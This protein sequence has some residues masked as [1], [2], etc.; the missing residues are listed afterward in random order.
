MCKCRIYHALTW[1]TRPLTASMGMAKPTPLLAPDGDAIA[2]LMPMSRP[3]P[4]SKTPP[5]LPVVAGNLVSTAV[6]I[7]KCLCSG[8]PSLLEACAGAAFMHTW[9]CT[10]V[11]LAGFGSHWVLGVRRL[12]ASGGCMRSLTLTS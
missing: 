11:D 9:G 3:R 1:S 12:H 10:G 5:E 6:G 2:V 8:E 4:S 7:I